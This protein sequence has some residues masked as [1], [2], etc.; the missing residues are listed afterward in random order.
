MED[1]LSLAKPDVAEVVRAEEALSELARQAARQ[2]P[3]WRSGGLAS[4]FLGAESVPTVDP[5]MR[6]VGG[7][8]EQVSGV[9]ESRWDRT[10]RILPRILFIAGL[11][12]AVTLGWLSSRPPQPGMSSEQPA[13]ADARNDGPATAGHESQPAVRTDAEPVTPEPSNTAA[14]TPSTAAAP[15]PSTAAS[16]APDAI[17]SAA[18]LAPPPAVIEQLQTITHD[19]A[20]LQQRVDQLASQQEQLLRTIAK[21]QAAERDIR[22]RKPVSQAA[23]PATTAPAP[24]PPPPQTQQQLPPPPVQPL[25]PAAAAEAPPPRPPG[26]IR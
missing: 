1:T 12:A 24:L 3:D 5:T 22:R 15:Q 6:S 18:P 21:L 10:G 13:A 25:P 23:V 4:H 26:S 11:G 9:R 17:G 19:V 16:T 20:S 8:N 14:P 7:R 2:S